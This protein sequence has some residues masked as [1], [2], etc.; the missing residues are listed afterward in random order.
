MKAVITFTHTDLDRYQAYYQ[1]PEQELLL[2]LGTVKEHECK[3]DDLFLPPLTTTLLRRHASWHCRRMPPHE[4]SSLN[5]EIEAEHHTTVKQVYS[6][7]AR[8]PPPAC[9]SMLGHG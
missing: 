2:Q 8:R 4:V 9:N 7:T 6:R 3:Y 5:D 1:R